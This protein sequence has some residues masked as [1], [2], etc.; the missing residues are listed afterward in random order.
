MEIDSSYW[1][2]KSNRGFLTSDCHEDPSLSDIRSN[3]SGNSSINNK[4][5]SHLTQ[6]SNTKPQGA[7]ISV[8][9]CEG[10]IKCCI[11]DHVDAQASE[12]NAIVTHETD[13][14]ASHSALSVATFLDSIISDS[15][16]KAKSVSEN[17]RS[18]PKVYAERLCS[19]Q[20][21][22]SANKRL[23]TLMPNKQSHV[24]AKPELR[25]HQDSGMISSTPEKK[26]FCKCGMGSSEADSSAGILHSLHSE[27][28]EHSR[29]HENSN[30]V[31]WK[32]PNSNRHQ[33]CSSSSHNDSQEGYSVS[34]S[35]FSDDGVALSV[36]H[37]P[38]LRTTKSVTS[39]S[40]S[41]SEGA[42]ICTCDCGLRSQWSSSGSAVTGKFSSSGFAG[43]GFRMNSY[44]QLSSVSQFQ[45]RR[46]LSQGKRTSLQS[47]SIPSSAGN[48]SSNSSVNINSKEMSTSSIYPWSPIG[49]I[50]ASRV[51]NNDK[52]YS[53]S[54]EDCNC[55]LINHQHKSLSGLHEHLYKT[56]RHDIVK[57]FNMDN[58]LCAP[59]TEDDTDPLQSEKKKCSTNVQATCD[60]SPINNTFTLLKYVEPFNNSNRS[61]YLPNKELLDSSC[62]AGTQ[63]DG[64]RRSSHCDLQEDNDKKLESNHTNTLEDTEENT[65]TDSP[66]HG[67]CYATDN[68]D[69]QNIPKPYIEIA[70]LPLTEL[71]SHHTSSKTETKSLHNALA[72]AKDTI[73]QNFLSL[74]PS[75]HQSDHVFSDVEKLTFKSEVTVEPV[76]RVKKRELPDF[77]PPEK[78]TYKP[79]LT[80]DLL[81]SPIPVIWNQ[82][83]SFRKPPNL[84]K[85]IVQASG[86]HHISKSAPTINI[87]DLPCDG[88]QVSILCSSKIPH[89]INPP[90]SEIGAELNGSSA[91]CTDKTRGKSKH[92]SNKRVPFILCGRLSTMP[93][94]P[95]SLTEFDIFAEGIGQVPLIK[96][97]QRKC[98]DTVQDEGKQAENT[99]MVQ[100]DHISDAQS[101]CQQLSTHS[102]LATGKGCTKTDSFD[103]QLSFSSENNAA[104]IAPSSL[105]ARLISA[106]S[107]PKVAANANA[108]FIGDN[109]SLPLTITMIQDV[110]ALSHSP[111]IIALASEKSNCNVDSLEE[112]KEYYSEEP[113]FMKVSIILD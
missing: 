108:V 47:S 96:L 27:H 17:V 94:I 91:A 70:T 77:T 31:D 76:E 58:S 65:S 84:E 54:E 2:P 78:L 15:V 25:I 43:P 81:N 98:D 59:S 109:V 50:F 88:K 82:E 97:P 86:E 69:S 90:L 75:L 53:I 52:F 8:V 6:T 112:K 83:S 64:M 102:N 111:S 79:C 66:F 103:D 28:V 37:L 46:S 21:L 9:N 61:A 99:S 22:P 41:E 95:V 107:E 30:A 35:N 40:E 100:A 14:V 5:N 19:V 92:G 24:T 39:L 113:T 11:N 1:I 57:P 42:H 12:R 56:S 105:D 45:Y 55:P 71:L 73:P 16:C 4:E 13:L 101:N 63:P 32:Y 72:S 44:S 80:M 29:L 7:E 60:M 34:P 85:T 87:L 110:P 106:N 89:V 23:K 74:I 48:L 33:L 68:M 10:G 104:D 20:S 18:I 49:S 93:I 3:F 36:E 38:E 67:T 26:L 51:S 62:N